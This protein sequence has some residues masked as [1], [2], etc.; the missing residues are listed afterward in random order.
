MHFAHRKPV[1][2]VITFEIIPTRNPTITSVTIS[3]VS[4]SKVCRNHS[5]AMK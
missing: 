2:H 5:F 4:A 3:P 1:K